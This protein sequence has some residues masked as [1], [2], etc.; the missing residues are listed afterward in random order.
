MKWQRRNTH[1]QARCVQARSPLQPAPLLHTQIREPVV[2]LTHAVSQS[3]LG[4]AEAA[5]LRTVTTSTESEGCFRVCC[6]TAVQE[7]AGGQHC[8]FIFSR[9]FSSTL[10]FFFF[11]VTP[12]S[13]NSAQ[14]HG[15]WPAPRAGLW[16]SLESEGAE[17]EDGCSGS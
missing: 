5:Q 17:D 11:L 2:V 12:V 13:A 15:N 9:F 6:F 4:R 1:V 16:E 7:L 8:N 3:L 10:S 14:V